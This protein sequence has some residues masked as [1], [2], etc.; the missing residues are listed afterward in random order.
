MVKHFVLTLSTGAQSLA[1]V[2]ADYNASGAQASET[3]W[4]VMTLQADTANTG[5]VFIGSNGNTILTTSSWGIFVPIPTSSVPAAPI[6]I[7]DPQSI[8]LDEWA[9]IS[10]AATDKLHIT[11]KE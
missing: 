3:A 4:S 1:K 10:A 2:Y 9:A 5:A 7:T 6:V 8:R 11:V